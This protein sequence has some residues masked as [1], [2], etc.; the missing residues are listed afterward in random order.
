[1]GSL[2]LGGG[3]NW[4][5]TQ[6]VGGVRVTY[7]RKESKISSIAKLNEI[8]ILLILLFLIKFNF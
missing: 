3:I 5:P 7:G 4:W 8:L 2:F 1:M 6:I